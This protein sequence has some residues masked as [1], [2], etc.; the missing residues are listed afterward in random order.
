MPQIED[1][2]PIVQQQVRQHRGEAPVAPAPAETRRKSLLEKLAA[3]GINRHDDVAPTPIPL[4]PRQMATNP[5]APAPA[6]QRAAPAPINQD[7]VRPQPRVAPPRPAQ[8]N[9]DPHGRASPRPAPLEEDHLEIP[10]FLRRQS[11]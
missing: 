9:L 4:A 10:A 3:F 8:G 5:P 1:L 11:N 2:P 6:P 7:Y